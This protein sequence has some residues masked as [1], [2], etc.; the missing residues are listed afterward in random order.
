MPL[1]SAPQKQTA[2]YRAEQNGQQGR[3]AP[4]TLAVELDVSQVIGHPGIPVHNGKRGQKRWEEQMER[5]KS[6]RDAAPKVTI[7]ALKETR[8]AGEASEAEDEQTE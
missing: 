8:E 3:N 5:R 4:R 7:A 2:G 6:A 1:N